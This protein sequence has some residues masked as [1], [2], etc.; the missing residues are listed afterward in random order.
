MSKDCPKKCSDCKKNFCPGARD[1]LCAVTADAPP[2]DIKN[3]FGNPLNP[4]LERILVD[5]WKAK[6]P[7]KEVSSI[8]MPPARR[9]AGSF[10][11][12]RCSGCD[13]DLDSDE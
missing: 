10:D 11:P 9:L 8:E 12:N 2:K 4:K 3:A 5:L 7:G 1:E 13:S 6:H